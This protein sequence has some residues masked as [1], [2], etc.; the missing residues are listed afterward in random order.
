MAQNGGHGID[1]GFEQPDQGRDPGWSTPSPQPARRSEIQRWP[2]QH[3]HQT[4][5]AG[6]LQLLGGL[7]ELLEQQREIDRAH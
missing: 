1:D 3:V 2:H 4:W 7:F 5:D 6:G